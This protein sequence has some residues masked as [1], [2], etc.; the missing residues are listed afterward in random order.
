M[1]GAMVW[2]DWHCYFMYLS[3]EDGELRDDIDIANCN[4]TSIAVKVDV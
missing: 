2:M 4:N 3:L 1:V